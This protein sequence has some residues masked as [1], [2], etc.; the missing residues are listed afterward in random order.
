MLLCLRIQI[1]YKA[2]SDLAN[3]ILAILY[4]INALIIQSKMYERTVVHRYER[5]WRLSATLTK[6]I[7][8]I[9]G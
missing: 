4:T 9:P 3:D 6:N 8:E 5:D 7:N 1:K 2:Q